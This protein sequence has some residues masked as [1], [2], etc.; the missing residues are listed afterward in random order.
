MKVEQ[1]RKILDN[2]SDEQE[3]M[4]ADFKEIYIVEYDGDVFITDCPMIEV[5]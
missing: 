3:V 5:E 1:L 2:Y 4:T